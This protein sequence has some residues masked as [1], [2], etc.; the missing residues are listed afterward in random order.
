MTYV[1]TK[2]CIDIAEP[3][4]ARV[5]LKNGE[6]MPVL[7]FGTYKMSDKHVLEA[8]LETAISNGY[9][10][11]D[12][13]STYDNEDL[14]G[15]ALK[16][17]LAKLQ[18]NRNELF[19]VSK[20]SPKEHGRDKVKK[21]VTTSLKKLQLNYLDMFLIHWPGAGNLKPNHPQNK[22]LRKESWHELESCVRDG[23]VKSIG[24]SNYTFPHLE[25]LYSYCSIEPSVNQV[26]FH[27][28]YRQKDDIIN[29]CS[30][31]NLLLQAYGS[32]GGE[33][34]ANVLLNDPT[35]VQVAQDLKVTVPQLLLRWSLQ[36]GFAVIPKSSKPERIQENSQLN[37]VIPPEKMKA[38]DGITTRK[39][40]D[41][42][43]DDIV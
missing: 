19:I 36:K 32:F 30:N 27:I 15:D 29:F 28:H 33:E 26:E 16:N 12:T 24:V 6:K 13:A 2:R 31:R 8:A 7:G 41:W 34:G 1:G 25:N 22:T 38:L 37:F 14:I 11:I 40:Y 3:K 10:L 18:I 5:T 21:A 35:A 17:V 9:R 39:K 4:K 23:L 43:P 20:L 42:N